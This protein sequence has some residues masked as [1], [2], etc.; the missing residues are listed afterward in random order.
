[1]ATLYQDPRHGTWYIQ[2]SK[3]GRRYRR[4]LNTKS[5]RDAQMLRHRIEQDMMKD[6]LNLL[7]DTPLPVVLKYFLKSRGDR[8]VKTQR[9]YET[10]L[11]Q[12]ERWVGETDVGSVTPA[13]IQGYR[14]HRSADKAAWTVSADMRVLATFFRW[15]VEMKYLAESPVTRSARA[16]TG[17]RKNT[18]RALTPSERR[19]YEEALQRDRLWP[20]YLFGVYAGLRR[21]EI[22]H[23]YRSDIRDGVIELRNHPDRGF[24]LKDYECRRIPLEPEIVEAL[25]QLPG[26]GRILPSPKGKSWQGNNIRRAWVKLMKKLKLPPERPERGTRWGCTVHELRH[27]YASVM[28]QERNVD[29]YTLARRMGHSSIVT[30]EGYFHQFQA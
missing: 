16:V 8:A 17:R 28:I 14:L 18:K 11:R 15:C 2:F 29:I 6:R 20:L 1:M 27:T 10:I 23:L 21:G 30:T 7:V 9:Y 24:S 25:S 4:S 5:H 12:F 3:N 13:T 22:A 26:R 19:T